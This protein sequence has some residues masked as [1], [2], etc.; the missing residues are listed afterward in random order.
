[1][2]GKHCNQPVQLQLGILQVVIH[3]QQTPSQLVLTLEQVFIMQFLPQEYRSVIHNIKQQLLLVIF[4][5]MLA[6]E[7]IR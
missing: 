2:L 1:M 5:D 6:K 4:L 3:N 7:Q